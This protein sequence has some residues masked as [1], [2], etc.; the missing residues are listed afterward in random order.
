MLNIVNRFD[1]TNG[2][3]PPKSRKE[4]KGREDGW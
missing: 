2:V 4:R 1:A 3:N